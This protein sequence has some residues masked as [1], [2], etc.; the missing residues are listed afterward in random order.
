MKQILKHTL[1]SAALAAVV[2][3][4]LAHATNGYFKIG[5]GSKN[6]GLAG[7]GMAFGQE[8][9]RLPLIRPH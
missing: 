8:P 9:W 3:S 4:P 2:A 7:T 5:Y 6:R 1:T